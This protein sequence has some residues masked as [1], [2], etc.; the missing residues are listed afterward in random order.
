MAAVS[1]LS[2]PGCYRL[3]VASTPSRSTRIP[4]I[5]AACVGIE[6][7]T[8]GKDGIGSGPGAQDRAGNRDCILRAP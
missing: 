6:G 2:L 5:A 7:M 4:A 3:T 1:A 8:A